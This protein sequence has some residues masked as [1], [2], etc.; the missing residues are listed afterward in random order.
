ML[1]DIWTALSSA[2]TS[3]VDWF[4]TLFTGMA[5]LFYTPGTGESAGSL[6]FIGVFAI[7][8]LVVSV[9]FVIIKWISSFISLRRN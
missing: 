6:T 5:Q 3:V 2:A 8:G 7:I 1:S 4:S 9:A